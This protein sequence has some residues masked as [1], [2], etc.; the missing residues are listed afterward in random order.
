MSHLRGLQRAA[1]KE[2]ELIHIPERTKLERNSL[3]QAEAELTDSLSR[4]P[5]DSELSDY[6]GLPLKRIQQIRKYHSPAVGAT[7]EGM[8]TVGTSETE[9]S[10]WQKFVYYSLT[11]IDQLIMEHTRGWN[12]KPVLG[13][14]ELAK[15]LKITPAA[16]SQ[17][18]AKIQAMIDEEQRDGRGNQ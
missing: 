5:A 11:P 4:P 3:M 12:G 16:I 1:G 8:P 17:R 6:M 15:K 10:G 2:T 9:D 13:T 7:Y 18:K 14:N